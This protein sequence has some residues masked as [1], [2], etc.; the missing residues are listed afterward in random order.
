[1][2]FLSFTYAKRAFVALLGPPLGPNSSG[3]LLGRPFREW[4][5]GFRDPLLAALTPPDPAAPW[6]SYDATWSARGLRLAAEP[7][8]AALAAQVAAGSAPAG[9]AAR[10]F[11]TAMAT[12]RALSGNVRDGA[13]EVLEDNGSTVVAHRNGSLRVAGRLPGGW[14]FGDISRAPFGM[15]GRPTLEWYFGRLDL[16]HDPGMRVGLGRAVPLT[17]DG[18]QATPIHE[19]PSL[20]YALAADALTPCGGAAA[21]ASAAARA[22]AAQACVTGDDV[23]GVWNLTA[24]APVFLTRAHFFGAPPALAA[25]LGPAAA[26]SFAPD[27]ATHNLAAVLDAAFGLPVHMTGSLQTVVG[28]RPSAVC[29]PQLWHGAPGPGGYTFF[30]AYWT[31]IDRQLPASLLMYIAAGHYA[32]GSGPRT[33][34]GILNLGGAV[35]AGFAALQLWRQR[36][37]EAAAEAAEQRSA[38]GSSVV[39]SGSCAED[40]WAASEA[41]AEADQQPPPRRGSA[42][43]AWCRD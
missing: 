23:D 25:S 6:W 14:G 1:M 16:V 26:A 39:S 33:V 41:D 30:P 38:R 27:A 17:W 5:F 20:R 42:T 24:S 4:H 21:G 36:A 22:A 43:Y 3:P 13:G 11:A 19:L 34:C 7:R 37:E 35:I 15:V 29:F 32:M 9:A 10:F 8:W 12:G 31:R 18:A 2:H 40:A 28:L